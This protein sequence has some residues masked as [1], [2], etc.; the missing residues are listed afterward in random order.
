M[1]LIE[2]LK[3]NADYSIGSLFSLSGNEIIQK[4]INQNTCKECIRAG[5][6]FWVHNLYLS[7][8]IRRY[9]C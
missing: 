4:K 5:V 2:I 3:G 7:D 8:F 9:E 1:Q 6:A